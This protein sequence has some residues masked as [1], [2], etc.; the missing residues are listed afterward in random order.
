MNKSNYINKLIKEDDN[1]SCVITS[2][3]DSNK[4]FKKEQKRKLNDNNKV[5]NK[6]INIGTSFDENSSSNFNFN[7]NE[8]I[9]S[10]LID[11]T[12]LNSI[13]SISTMN[14]N[15][16]SSL[17]YL[18]NNC[19]KLI[20][21]NDNGNMEYNKFITEKRLK[22]LIRHYKEY[23]NKQKLIEFEI[24]QHSLK[25]NEIS[26]R[27]GD[28][29]IN[30]NYKELKED[31]LRMESSYEVKQLKERVV[32]KLNEMKSKLPMVKEFNKLKYVVNTKKCELSAT[33]QNNK[34]TKGN[35]N[36][37]IIYYKNI[38]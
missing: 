20:K 34:Q 3:N 9:N 31:I 2:S 5:S 1:S 4:E 10:K 38:K 18:R 37:L 30:Y 14:S 25:L 17:I 35:I 22:Y 36:S 16:I 11:K 13:I 12:L 23:R 19:I 21:D 33:I 28:L 6:N 24:K 27:L 7:V 8:S 26:N 32:F 15:S 29:Y